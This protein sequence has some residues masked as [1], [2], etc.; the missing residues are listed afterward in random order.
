MRFATRLTVSVLVLFVLNTL[1][2]AQSSTTSVRGT[3]TDKS[4]AAVAN[5]KVTI[6]NPAQAIERT[7][8][9]GDAGQYEFVQLPPGT[10]H[11]SVE[12]AGFRRFEHKN[13]Q[14]LVS[15]P[16]HA[17]VTLEVGE[18]ERSSRSECRSDSRQYHRRHAR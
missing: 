15:N 12:A 18:F 14:L 16:S 3:V 5:A 7:M 9:S 17:D 10:Y 1:I 2:W 6:S 11:L 8:N 13:V 4:G